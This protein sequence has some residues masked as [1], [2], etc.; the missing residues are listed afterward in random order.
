ME[1]IKKAAKLNEEDINSEEEEPREVNVEEEDKV[2]VQKEGSKVGGKD[3]SK[4][5][6]DDF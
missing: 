4:F 5:T 1:L 2:I 6:V 3:W